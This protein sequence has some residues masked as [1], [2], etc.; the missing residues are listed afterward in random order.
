MFCRE[1]VAQL[2]EAYP[3][4]QA[5]GAQVLV[6]GNGRPEQAQAFRKEFEVPF[7]LLVDPELAAYAA[8]GLKRGVGSTF[9][10]RVVKN[11][12]RSRG[13]GFRQGRVQGD[14]WQQGG[15][16]AIAADGE[17]VYQHVEQVGGEKAPAEELLAALHSQPL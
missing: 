17:L 4:L 8:A 1:S 9:H 2:R 10:P 7:E 3:Q 12:F 15:T 6:V 14:P 5:L 11:F 13:R 16:F